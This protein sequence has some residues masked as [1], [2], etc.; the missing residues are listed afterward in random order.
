MGHV[1]KEK[2]KLLNR[3]KRLRGQLEGI[4]RAVENDQECADVLQQATA[5]RG[6]LDG[7]IAEVIEDHILEHM[8]D[9]DAPRGD[10]YVK[11]AEELVEIVHRY[12]KR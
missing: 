7:F 5:C 2:E 12:F 11:A 9:P 8:V 6:A 4:E 1:A 10:P 3:I